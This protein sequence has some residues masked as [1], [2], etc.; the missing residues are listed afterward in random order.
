[1]KKTAHGFPR[2]HRI[3]GELIAEVFQGELESF[4]QADGVGN[5]FGQITK[6]LAHL[7]SALEESLA[8]LREQFAGGIQVGMMTN[9]GEDI[10]HLTANRS[11]VKHAIGG[12]Q[13]QTIMPCEFTQMAQGRFFAPK[14]MAL[15]FHE[16]TLRTENAE[17]FFQDLLRRWR[18]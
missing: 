11:G 6:E 3:I 4:G 12:Q 9:A 18:L 5:R 10:Q 15:D 17:Q 14:L 8:V 1:M 2:W 13:G 7:R 16:K